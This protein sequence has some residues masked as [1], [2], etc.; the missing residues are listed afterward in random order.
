MIDCKEKEDIASQYRIRKLTSLECW[1][2]MGF[3]DEDF[4]KA[5]YYKKEIG[6]DVLCSVKLKG[7]IE[8]RSQKDMGTYVLNIT[9][10]LQELGVTSTEWMKLLKEEKSVNTVN[11]NI[12]IEKLGEQAH[13]ECVINIIK[14]LE[15]M[16]ILYGLTE[17]LDR[18]HTAIIELGK[19]GKGNTAKYMRITS[20]GSCSPVKLFIILMVLELTIESKIFTSTLQKVNIRRL[21]VNCENSGNNMVKMQISNLKMEGIFTRNSSSQLY[22]QA[23]NSI[24][25]CTL[26][27]I[28]KN[29]YEAM[30]YLFD[31]L[32]VGSFFSGIGAFEKALDM[33]Q[34]D[35]RDGKKPFFVMGDE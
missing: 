33:L 24:T 31:G 26:Y 5:A 25:T 13:L 32:K 22:K 15:S 10:G 35:L 1:R 16:A 23:G 18:H 30:P 8:K 19:R 6:G 9:N 7:V 4:F 27:Y 14:C 20:E 29:L 21:T 12:A 28:Y 2:L 11:A 17:E 3:S 34:E